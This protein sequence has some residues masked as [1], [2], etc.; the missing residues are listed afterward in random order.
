ML[1]SMTGYGKLESELS[2]R[3]LMIQIKTVNSKNADLN[4]KLPSLVR[5]RESELRSELISQLVRGKIDL[6]L[7]IESG[8]EN[9]AYQIN[10]EVLNAYFDELKD[11]AK[12][13]HISD[14]DIFSVASRFPNVLNQEKESPPDS[15]W[16]KIFTDIKTVIQDVVSFRKHEGAV[17]EEDLEKRIRI[18]RSLNQEIIPLEAERIEKVKNKLNDQ[19]NQLDIVESINRD[20]FEQ[21]MIYYIEKYDLTEEK[22]R[23]NSHLDL[24]EETM[25]DDNAQGR[26]LGFI[27]QEIGR[28]IN[29]IGSKANHAGIQRC[30][31]EMKDELEKI[32]EQLFNVL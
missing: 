4:I 5:D 7:I 22:V 23:L 18:I 8:E 29:T 14:T 9:Q 30:V 10:R 25:K 27:S 31:V 26:K 21:E 20:R 11:I 16:D 12:E 13:K 28:E 2:G 19:L 24:F 15:E 3:K 32:K 6:T 1:Q 17:M